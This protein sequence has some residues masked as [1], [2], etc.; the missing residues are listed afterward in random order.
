MHCLSCNYFDL[1][2]GTAIKMLVRSK[3]QERLC[4]NWPDTM[5]HFKPQC[6]CILSC[7]SLILFNQNDLSIQLF[8]LFDRDAIEESKRRQKKEWRI[9]MAFAAVGL[10]LGVYTVVA[11]AREARAM[12][13]ERAFDRKMR[14]IYAAHGADMDEADMEKDTRE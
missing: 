1:R 3:V 12:F 14:E 11:V 8:L 4:K 5:L 6:K 2:L 9:Y 10:G 7:P 13:R